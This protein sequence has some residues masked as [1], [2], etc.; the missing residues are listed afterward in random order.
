MTLPPA[1]IGLLVRTDYQASGLRLTAARRAID[2]DRFAERIRVLVHPLSDRALV[3]E[4]TR[5]ALA[6]LG[7]DDP[8]RD[9]T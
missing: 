7:V 4:L 1:L 6:Y 3:G 9:E 5:A 8:D 2:D